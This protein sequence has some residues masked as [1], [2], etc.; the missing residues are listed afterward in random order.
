MTEQKISQN[1]V[2]GYNAPDQPAPFTNGVDSSR[3][4]PEGFVNSA[5]EKEKGTGEWRLGY[6]NI[7][8]SGGF[9]EEK[10]HG[11]K[12]VATSYIDSENPDPN[13]PKSR[14]AGTT[15]N[16]GIDY[17][18]QGDKKVNPWYG[19][20]VEQAK[21]TGEGYG[22][23]V[24]VKTNQNYEHGGK[25]YPI[26]TAYSHLAS[27]SVKQGQQVYP[28]TSLGIMGGTGK[29]PPYPDHV[30]F[31]SY[32]NV[33][34][35]KIQV[36]PN[37]IQDQLKQKQKEGRFNYN[38]SS[39]GSNTSTVASN[40]EAT[41]ANNSKPNVQANQ[42]SSESSGRGVA[43]NLTNRLKKDL[44]GKGS[45]AVAQAQ[46]FNGSLAY[47]SN[48]DLVDGNQSVVAARDE[49]NVQSSGNN[50]PERKNGPIQKA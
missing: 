45:R 12:G 48:M 2:H 36:S 34:G 25:K 50:K 19:G 10:G 15:H 39:N 7:Q 30:D 47:N 14:P 4:I 24:I 26:Y 11:R 13:N 21:N 32:I 38:T 31:Q 33:N 42:S 16:I 3:R 29:T 43:T 27:I 37:L 40:T 41:T 22:N 44:V 1:D 6:N 49:N 46:K 5:A 9:M 18:V 28:N 35:K 20:T 23:Q 17:V 8:M